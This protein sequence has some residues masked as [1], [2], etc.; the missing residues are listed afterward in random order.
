MRR[1]A[2][3]NPI[4]TNQG[5]HPHPFHSSAA[6]N[7]TTL[8]QTTRHTLN[9][10]D[11]DAEHDA[12]DDNDGNKEEKENDETGLMRT[13]M[14]MMMW[15]KM[16]MMIMM[17]VKMTMMTMTVA[18]RPQR[19]ARRSIHVD[20]KLR[21]SRGADHKFLPNLSNIYFPKILR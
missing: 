21:P 16:A 20:W 14:A 12:D 1:S 17:W 3:H 8:G 4:P 15:M 2:R 19:A 18:P 6:G 13:M 5:P 9:A 11:G 7:P 10:A